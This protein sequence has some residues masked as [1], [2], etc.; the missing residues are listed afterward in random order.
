MK[1]V[2]VR[3]YGFKGDRERCA[4][5]GGRVVPLVRLQRREERNATRMRA[6]RCMLSP[7]ISILLRHHIMSRVLARQN[8]A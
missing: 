5:G 7:Y 3:T 2:W 8:T 4:G 6:T 1:P